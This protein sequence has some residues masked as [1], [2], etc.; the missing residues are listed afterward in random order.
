MGTSYLESASQYMF[1]LVP[2]SIDRQQ[3]VSDC[4]TLQI[5]TNFEVCLLRGMFLW[6]SFAR[7]GVAVF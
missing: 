6:L 2:R 1:D 7:K 4:I 5:Y 3:T